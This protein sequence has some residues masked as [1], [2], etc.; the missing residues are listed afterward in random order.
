MEFVGS[1]P[2]PIWDKALEISRKESFPAE[3]PK[4][5]PYI[6]LTYV[7]DKQLLTL[8]GTLKRQHI[9]L[10]LT[11][12]FPPGEVKKHVIPGYADKHKAN[13]LIW[14]LISK[15]LIAFLHTSSTN[16]QVGIKSE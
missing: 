8:T 1:I 4:S 14:Q 5:C 10:F 16:N 9:D 11:D 12:V 15:A 13:R 3:Q 2:K 6:I 7:T